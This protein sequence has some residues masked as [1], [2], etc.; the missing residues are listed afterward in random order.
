MQVAGHHG[1]GALDVARG[2]RTLFV[3]A[4]EIETSW[5]LFTPVLENKPA[6]QTY[7][8]GSWGPTAANELVARYGQCWT[9]A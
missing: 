8:S 4:D 6:I 5:D 3:R 2:D 1:D 9:E 7:A